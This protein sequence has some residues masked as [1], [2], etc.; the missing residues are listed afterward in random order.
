MY[1]KN[2]LPEDH[3]YYASKTELQWI[4]EERVLVQD[5]VGLEMYSN[6]F[7][8]SSYIYY[9]KEHTR[10]AT[11][12]ELEHW[13]NIEHQKK[14]EARQILKK[15]RAEQEE[16]LQCLENQRHAEQEK[17]ERLDTYESNITSKMKCLH[18]VKKSKIICLD[19]ET[20]G[21][22]YESDEIL[23]ISILDGTGR[24][25]MDEY[26]KPLSTT[27]WPIAEN[28]NH[29]SPEMVKDCESLQALLP[30]I[31]K[32]IDTANLIVGYNVIFDLM[33][34]TI[35]GLSLPDQVIISDVM[36]D[37]APIYGDWNDYFGNY[38]WKSL[39]TCASYFDY[40][41]SEDDYHNSLTDAKVTLYCFFAIQNPELFLE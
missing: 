21:L 18:P 6:R 7:H 9:P 13:H 1:F 40:Q 10:P 39:S 20:T 30:S 12:E 4:K 41:V 28:I 36:Q 15:K 17:R 22:N 26:T 2:H 5:A 25:L 11:P 16:H 8:N 31:Q 3:P 19:V 33:F 38:T 32:I 37:F 24:V 27:E 14:K 29:I 34:L 35:A 23:Q